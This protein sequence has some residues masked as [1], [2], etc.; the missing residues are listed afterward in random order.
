MRISLRLVH[1]QHLPLPTVPDAAL[2]VCSHI[3]LPQACSPGPPFPCLLQLL[4]ESCREGREGRARPRRGTLA[5]PNSRTVTALS[6]KWH[7][8]EPAPTS[9]QEQN[10]GCLACARLGENTVWLY[11]TTYYFIMLITYHT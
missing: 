9:Q 6:S 2:E 7:S 10:S 4:L 11:I 1:T 8:P 5:P 3:L